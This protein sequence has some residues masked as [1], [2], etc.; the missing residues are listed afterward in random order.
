MKVSDNEFVRAILWDK[1][2]EVREK[3]ETLEREDVEIFEWGEGEE[4]FLGVGMYSLISDIFIPDLL[5]RSVGGEVVDSEL[6]QRA[7]AALERILDD[8]RSGVQEMV[9]IR[10]VDYLLGEVHP[11]LRFKIFAGPLMSAEVER[12][13]KFYVG[14]F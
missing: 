10:V 8:G 13:K 5:E 9:D 4:D 11:W 6:A 2:P 3:I 14:P 1:F 7:A 12:R